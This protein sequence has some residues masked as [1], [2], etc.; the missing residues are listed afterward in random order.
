LSGRSRC[1]LTWPSDEAG[2][3]HLTIVTTHEQRTTSRQR[4][5]S[6]LTGALPNKEYALGLYPLHDRDPCHA[7]I[8]SS[9]S[10]EVEGV[11]KKDDVAAT[12]SLGA[13]G[14]ERL[15]QGARIGVARVH[16]HRVAAGVQHVVHECPS[17]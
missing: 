17:P 12:W 1:P 6:H 7:V 16:P 11:P 4:H 9:V 15:P 5:S 8:G 3:S 10:I 13:M 2:V 14:A